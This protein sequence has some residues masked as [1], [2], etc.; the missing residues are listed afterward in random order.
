MKGGILGEGCWVKDALPQ[1]LGLGYLSRID[2]PYSFYGNGLNPHSTVGDWGN[3][4]VLTTH[5][6]VAIQ[7]PKY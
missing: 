3:I 6:A 7:C 4:G 1:A 2:S 5:F